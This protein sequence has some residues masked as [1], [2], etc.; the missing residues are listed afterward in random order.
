VTHQ[1][2]GGGDE[3][4]LA[5]VADAPV[6]ASRDSDGHSL[7]KRIIVYL[8]SS[9]VPAM[10]TLATSVIFTRIFNPVAYGKYSLFLVYAA[11]LELLFIE[12][13]DQSI[14]KYLPPV[15]SPEDRHRVKDAI[16]LSIA[17]IV[18]AEIA[19]SA[20]V[21]GL[22]NL[23]VAPEWRS[24]L[25]PTAVFIVVSSLFDIIAIVF[26]A[27]YRAREYTSYQLTDSVVT[28]LLRLL[29]VSSIFSMD[30][31]LMFWSVIV[32][33]CLL[34]PFMW[35]RG[36]L[37][38]PRRLAI[39]LRS[40]EIRGTAR[41]FLVFGLPMTVFFLSSVLLDVGDRY[42]LNILMGPASVG[43]YDTNYRLIAGVVVLMVAPVTI[44]LHPYLMR[45]AGSGDS[46]LIEQAIGSVVE[47]LLLIGALTVGLTFLLHGYIARI[48]LGPEFR[49]GSVVMPPVVAGVFFFNIGTFVHKP[50]EIVGRTHVMLVFGV[51]AAAADIGL[52]FAL[53]PVM[54]YDGAA[55]A[56]LFSYV[57][58]TV[59]VGYLGWRIFPWRVNLRRLAKY[60]VIMGAGL[61]AV[62]FLRDAMSGL[63]YWWSLT[64]TVVVSCVLASICLLA[65][66][67]PMRAPGWPGGN[68]GPD[69]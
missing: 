66:L 8:P 1:E 27:E 25:V 44:T 15:Q 55:Y 17:L 37:P 33:H 41:L 58:Y 61:V 10:L 31:R 65:V 6:E 50:F 3:P 9:I 40:S 57:I 42:V 45:V 49:A 7:L 47:N 30:I 68:A 11:P 29:L 59:C 13:L 21:L 14:G 2:A 54:G 12:W 64:I 22:G 67:L 18:L 20:V 43:I 69:Q 56:T 62:S 46:R 34:L 51:I 32:S 26:A 24:F 23:L 39:F 52:C 16:F 38:T 4:G 35:V 53:I 48:V 19:V 5:L 36:G 63:P 60:G 28:F